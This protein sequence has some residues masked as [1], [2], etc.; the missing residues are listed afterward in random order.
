MSAEVSVEKGIIYNIWPRLF[1][2]FKSKTSKLVRTE[3]EIGATAVK[4]VI[5]ILTPVRR[6]AEAFHI[7]FPNNLQQ[8]L[9]LTSKL[10]LILLPILCL[11]H[12]LQVIT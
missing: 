6:Q 12:V 3:L 10:F 2:A 4:P 1:R 7:K 8:Q 11:Y 9:H 5:Y